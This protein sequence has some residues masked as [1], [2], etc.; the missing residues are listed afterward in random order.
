VKLAEYLGG[1]RLIRDAELAMLA[2]E[3]G[4][5]SAEAKVLR[6]L[7]KAR[8]KDRQFEVVRIGDT[9]LVG[10]PAD[11]VTLALAVDLLAES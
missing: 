7:R 8:A 10:P 9:Y 11:L 3:G 5:S 4:R 2:K 1:V 6:Q